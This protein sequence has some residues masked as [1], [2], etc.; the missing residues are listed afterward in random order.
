[1][2][3]KTTELLNS[4]TDTILNIGQQYGHIKFEGLDNKIFPLE[5]RTRADRFIYVLKDCSIDYF[6]LPIYGIID[7]KYLLDNVNHTE[8]EYIASKPASTKYLLKWIKILV[9]I[10]SPELT[11]KIRQ[12]QNTVLSINSPIDIYIDTILSGIYNISKN[13][14]FIIS[15]YK[16]A[17]NIDDILYIHSHK[18]KNYVATPLRISCEYGT[19]AIYA[20]RYINKDW[21]YGLLNP[22]KYGDNYAI[23]TD[24]NILND[25]YIDDSNTANLFDLAK[26]IVSFYKYYKNPHF[27]ISDDIKIV[28][29]LFINSLLLLID[30]D[31]SD[32]TDYKLFFAN[33]EVIKI[34]IL[35]NNNIKVY[36]LYNKGYVFNNIH[37]IITEF[38]IVYPNIIPIDFIVKNNNAD[39]IYLFD[40]RNK[41][42]F[43][44]I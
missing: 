30:K 37:D 9:N 43:S 27:T 10:N 1:M 11:S 16:T 32:T 6:L 17:D 7:T 26:W 13:K 40:L 41:I 21:P 36:L 31:E 24:K 23:A 38:R 3:F 4:K 22:L 44:Y 15:K 20:S 42:K 34:I 12:I 33:D 29:P 14:D 28:K 25:V 35:I 2:E 8:N 39:S 18:F 19:I 5:L